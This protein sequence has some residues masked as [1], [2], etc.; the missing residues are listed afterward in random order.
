VLLLIPGIIS[1]I[2]WQLPL[3]IDFRG[4]G[5]AEWRFDKA[6]NQEELRSFLTE[7]G[8]LEGISLSTTGEGTVLIKF[9]PVEEGEY[10]Q[11]LVELEKEF[12]NVTEE[13]FENVG[14]SVSEDITKRAIIVVI[15]ASLFILI[16]LAYSFRGVT[17]PVSSWRFGGVALIALIHDLAISIGVFSILAHYFGF[18]VD[19]SMITAM[20]TIMGFSVH[21]TIVVFDRIRENIHG[22]KVESAEEFEKIADASLSQTLNRSL[23]TSLTLVFALLALLVLG[24]DSIRSFIVMMTVGVVVGTYSSIF[25]ATPLLTIWQN[26]IFNRVKN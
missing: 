10:R 24:G 22:Q 14:P 16:Y 11:S 19:S 20:L 12:G 13:K 25:T 18:E 3:G 2:F 1:L 4:G 26:K 23:G 9:L 15:V 17:Y 5:S 7:Q 8:T 21:D 6:V